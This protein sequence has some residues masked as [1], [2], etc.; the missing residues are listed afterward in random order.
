MKKVALILFSAVLIP[1]GLSQAQPAEPGPHG[2]GGPGGPGKGPAGPPHGKFMMGMFDRVAKEL[3]EKLSFTPEQKTKFDA[4]AQKHRA[5]IEELMKKLEQE[6]K[7]FET[8]LNAMLT[9]EQQ[10]K[11]KE[12]KKAREF[13]QK[14]FQE[15]MKGQ[16]PEFR[17]G[18]IIRA[19]KE[20][21]LPPEKN[22]KVLSILTD[23][24]AKF[25]AAPKGDRQA[26]QQIMK[27]MMSKIRETL[28]PEEFQRLKEILHEQ[29][30]P[31]G[32]GPGRGGPGGPEGRGPG[33]N[34]PCPEGRPGEPLPPPPS[35]EE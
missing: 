7:S 27:E 17:Q 24:R 30:G 32:R 16:S 31:M 6:R 20:L 21:N 11:L 2:P 18:M 23:Y 35:D 5:N 13:V 25:Q 34:Q 14:R 26:R 29:R 1:I 22:E 9:P 8:D 28:A 19:V 4:L 10:A 12:L 33:M 15:G 3:P